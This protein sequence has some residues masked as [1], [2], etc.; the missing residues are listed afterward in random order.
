MSVNGI[1]QL[2][3]D[4]AATANAASSKGPDQ[5]AGR[6]RKANGGSSQFAAQS[7]ASKS[8]Q[9]S[10]TSARSGPQPLN[11]TGRGRIVNILV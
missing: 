3:V 7:F 1:G 6:A 5:V 10:T 8:Y 11:A 2:P 4:P 9:Q